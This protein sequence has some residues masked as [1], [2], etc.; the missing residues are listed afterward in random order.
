[1]T[2]NRVP[3]INSEPV[4]LHVVVFGSTLNATVPFPDPD[5]PLVTRIQTLLLTAVHGQPVPVVT[6]LVALPPAARNDWLVGDTAAAHEVPACVTVSVAPAMVSVLVRL[7]VRVFAATSNMTLP[8]PD[9]IVPAVTV[10]HGALLVAVQSHPVAA[11]TVL[12]PVPP[13]AAND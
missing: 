7:D 6:V 9:P 11:A 4:R 12:I 3:A 2:V 1:M 5:A 8:S 13:D 10:I